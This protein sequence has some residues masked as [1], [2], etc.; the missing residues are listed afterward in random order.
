MPSVQS[1]DHLLRGAAI[2]RKQGYAI[3]RIVFGGFAGIINCGGTIILFRLSNCLIIPRDVSN[4][5]RKAAFLRKVTRIIESECRNGLARFRSKLFLNNKGVTSLGVV[6]DGRLSCNRRRPGNFDQI[7]SATRSGI[8]ERNLKQSSPIC[9]LRY[10]YAL[11]FAILLLVI[12]NRTCSTF[13]VH[14]GNGNALRFADGDRLLINV[15]KFKCAC[16]CDLASHRIG[17]VLP[18]G[19]GAI[20]GD[21]I[22]APVNHIGAFTFTG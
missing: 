16:V 9:R 3:V 14:E 11:N 8:V 20:F 21:I 12:Q 2:C 10:L 13:R 18:F 6:G 19:L 5:V 15:N 7:V 17:R 1:N 22:I 4:C